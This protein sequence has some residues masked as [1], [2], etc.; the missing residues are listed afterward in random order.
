MPFIEKKKTQREIMRAP[1]TLLR[2]TF[3]K[4]IKALSRKKKKKLKHC[5]LS[6][7][8]VKQYIMNYSH[9]INRCIVFN[10]FYILKFK[11]RE[12]KLFLVERGKSI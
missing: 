1:Q 9:S 5:E 12:N 7:S 3:V 2:G 4:I 8:R 10:L 11:Q 6:L